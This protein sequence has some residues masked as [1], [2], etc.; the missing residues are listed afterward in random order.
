MFGIRYSSSKIN[1]LTFKEHFEDFAK[2]V[3]LVKDSN[4]PGDFRL[5]ASMVTASHWC[6]GVRGRLWSQIERGA[7][8]S[9]G[10]FPWQVIK[11]FHKSFIDSY[12][13]FI[14]SPIFYEVP[15]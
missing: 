12:L 7:G 14:P 15:G 4:E 10:L 5:T 8:A 13:V 6:N 3:A 11:G 2:K 1:S 9:M